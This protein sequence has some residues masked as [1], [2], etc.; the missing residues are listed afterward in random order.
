MIDP[1]L[2]DWIDDAD[3][4]DGNYVDISHHL[5]NWIVREKYTD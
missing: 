4:E 3:D 1:L 5:K 2:E